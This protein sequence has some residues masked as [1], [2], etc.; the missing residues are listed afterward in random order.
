MLHEFMLMLFASNHIF[1]KRTLHGFK[2][3]AFASN[4]FCLKRMLHELMCKLLPQI[5][6][7]SNGCRRDRA[8]FLSP[9]LLWT[10][11]HSLLKL[12]PQAVW[13][14]KKSWVIFKTVSPWMSLLDSQDRGSR[15]RRDPQW[16]FRLW[17]IAAQPK[18]ILRLRVYLNR[19]SIDSRIVVLETFI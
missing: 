12:T 9:L 17:I 15:L 5:I 16:F 18:K 4:H 8:W 14:P 7:F 19:Q 10:S 6:S 1:L 2:V 13:Q 11:R 3:Y